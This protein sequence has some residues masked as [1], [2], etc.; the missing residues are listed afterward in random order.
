M[1]GQTLPDK[2][3][4]GNIAPPQ[5]FTPEQCI[6]FQEVATIRDDRDIKPGMID[7]Q[8]PCDVGTLFR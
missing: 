3:A 1:L 6:E 7:V 8:G 2:P 5:A 4:D